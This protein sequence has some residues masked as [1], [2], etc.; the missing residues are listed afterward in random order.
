VATVTT[1]TKTP[2]KTVIIYPAPDV[3]DHGET[4]DGEGGKKDGKHPV[5]I[6]KAH[7]SPV[8]LH[9]RVSLDDRRSF[10]SAVRTKANS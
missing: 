8:V 5:H 1:R 2:G 3:P 7:P 10:R 9:R 4:T 6:K